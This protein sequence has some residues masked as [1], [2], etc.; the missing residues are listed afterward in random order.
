MVH[1]QRGQYRIGL[2]DS[3]KGHFRVLTKGS[4]DESPDF[5]PNG[6][7]I[8]YAA[9]EG[10]AGVLSVVSVDGRAQQQLLSTQGD[11]REPAWSPYSRR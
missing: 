5:S 10:D 4:H 6:R 11:V 1:A 2:L 7:M 3:K 8:I 9:R